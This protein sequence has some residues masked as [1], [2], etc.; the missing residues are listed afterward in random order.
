LTILLVRL[1]LIG[2][3]VFTT[4]MIRALRRTFPTARLLYLVESS[5]APIVANNPHLDR[6]ITVP[7]TRGWR[8]I[9]D[10]WR[11]SRDLRR[12]R[13]DVA[14][15]LHGGPRSALLT[16]ATRAPVRVGYDVPGR[17]WMYTRT[18]HRPRELRP[19]HSVENQWDL[20]AAVDPQ[21]S[22]PADPTHDRVEMRVAPSVQAEVAARLDG[23]AVPSDAQLIV[24]HVSAGNPFR[25][26][27]ES[28]FAELARG[29]VA[30]GPRRWVLVTSGP[31]DHEAA[32]RVIA[33]ARRMSGD[34]GARIVDVEGLT[35]SGLRAL[36]DRAALF[37]G[38]DSGPL[39]VAA[40]SDVPVVGLY[41]P[42]LAERSAPWRPRDILT[43]S[44]D[45]GPLPCRPCEQRVCV[46]G[47]FRC[48]TSIDAETVLA[49]A[50]RVLVER[51]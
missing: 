4:P 42:T 8:R 46:P 36:F 22:S 31:S 18:V 25:R 30:A 13:V 29:L 23:L 37:V 17:Q 19:R 9:G 3:V 28:A 15:D 6:V 5:A 34:A 11:L 32:T 43:A 24:L 44:V 33:D 12:E 21:L 27:P 2:D 14:I 35:L 16:W 50:E 49:A 45:A 20:L 41:G 10:D 40:T 38:G 39:H 7:H 47:D 26:W 48:L 1:R 51:R